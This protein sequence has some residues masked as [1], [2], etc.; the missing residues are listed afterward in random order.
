MPIK[1]KIKETLMGERS[2]R[3]TSILVVLAV[4][5]IIGAVVIGINDNLP[6]IVLCYIAAILIFVAFTHTWQ[7]RRFLIL[8]AASFAGFFI[9]VLLHNAFYALG[10]VT[11]DIPGVSH[12]LE[13]SH[14]AFFCL[15][16]FICPPGFAVGAVGSIIFAVRKLRGKQS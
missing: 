4:I 12:F 11:G 10:V 9:F 1:E 2:R 6:G 5:L 13:F 14:V 7:R 16:V 15:A 3:I 8:T